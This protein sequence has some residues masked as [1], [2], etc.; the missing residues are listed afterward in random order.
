MD[1]GGGSKRGDGPGPCTR[2]LAPGLRSDTGQFATQARQP[3]AYG[4]CYKLH[5]SG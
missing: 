2:F 4:V 5:N 1:L 3:Y